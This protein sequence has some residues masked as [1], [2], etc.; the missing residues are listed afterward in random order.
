MLIICLKVSVFCFTNDCER[1]FINKMD[2]SGNFAIHYDDFDA[3]HTYT[4]HFHNAHEIIFIRRG[5]AELQISGKK[6]TVGANSM[7]FINN[8]ESH[9]SKILEYPYERFFILAD[10]TYLS[11]AADDA[12]LLTIFKQKPGEA[13][14]VIALD[15]AHSDEIYA[16]LS[17][18]HKEY[19]DALARSGAF[20]HH[21]INLILIDLYRSYPGYF[22][23]P[24]ADRG[25]M[26]IRSVESYVAENFTRDISLAS[27]AQL[28]SC[29]MYYL[30]HLFLKVTGYGFKQYLIN[31]RLSKAKELL[32]TTDVS[33]SQVCVS[34]GFNNV[35]HFIRLFKQKEGHTPLQYRIKYSRQK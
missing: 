19:T 30:S 28:F 8:L 25:H 26:L 18:I 20:I 10:Q 3:P 27:A 22:P 24:G 23:G 15:D 12:A 6:Y 2:L 17:R 33:I 31:H 16:F 4:D 5:K 11:S 35:N 14:H 29:D 32:L 13:N 34:S 9:K 7:V 1:T 21:L